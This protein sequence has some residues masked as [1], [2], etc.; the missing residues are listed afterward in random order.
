MDFSDLNY[1]RRTYSSMGAYQ[2]SKLANVLFSKE[3][4]RRLQAANIDVKV[5]CLHPGLVSTEL[6]RHLHVTFPIFSWIWH[7]VGKCF[8]KTPVEG[9]QTTI[10]CAVDNK[11][12]NETGL[13]YADCSTA[14]VS[15]N[16]KNTKD[17]ERLW[18]ESLKLVE[19][20]H[21]YNPFV[22]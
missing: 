22:Y 20:P 21:D 14:S 4:A 3:L 5:Y 13:Y 17:A 9:A 7:Y 12:S 15:T 19:L 8:M 16:A 6:G 18:S 11:C 1:E 10:Y 2:Q